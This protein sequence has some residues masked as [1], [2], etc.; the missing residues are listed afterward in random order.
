MTAEHHHLW[1]G[2]H[3]VLKGKEQLFCLH[4]IT[5]SS[6]LPCGR[7]GII[8]LFTVFLVLLGNS[9]AHV[10]HESRGSRSQCICHV[11]NLLSIYLACS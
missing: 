6:P 9:E 3:H 7:Y 2:L 1:K 11:V 5:F 10:S 4:D 8:V